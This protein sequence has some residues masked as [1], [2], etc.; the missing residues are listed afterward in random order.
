MLLLKCSAVLKSISLFNMKVSVVLGEQTCIALLCVILAVVG[1]ESFA[2]NKSHKSSEDVVE[3]EQGHESDVS[4][5]IIITC[6][7]LPGISSVP[8][9]CPHAHFLYLLIGLK[10]ASVPLQLLYYCII[11]III[12]EGVF[13]LLCSIQCW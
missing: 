1:E 12:M 8:V 9:S 6:I 10:E 13:F 11:N 3:N 7:T 4:R 5:G 2:N